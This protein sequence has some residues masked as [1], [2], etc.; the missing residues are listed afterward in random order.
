VTV[1]GAD[2]MMV[3]RLRV[4]REFRLADT[5]HLTAVS[6]GLTREIATVTPYVL[7]QQWAAAFEEAGMCG[8]R[9]ES[10]FSTA[11]RANAVALFGTDGASDWLQGESRSGRVVAQDAGIRVLP[12]PRSRSLRVVF[13]PV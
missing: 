1:A 6:F 10:R 4:P 11:A 8:V 13:P 7:P 2:S 12:R 9:Y 3:S 5:C